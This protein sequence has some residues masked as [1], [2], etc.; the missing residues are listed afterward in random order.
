MLGSVGAGF[1]G[2]G[3]RALGSASVDASSAVVRGLATRAGSTLAGTI[4]RETV[5]TAAGYGLNRAGTA[6]LSRLRPTPPQGQGI[7]Y[8][9][10]DLTGQLKPY[11]GQAIPTSGR[12]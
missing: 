8:L 5:T 12:P 7:V 1:A 3:L 2:A 11:V 10:E 4:L 9:R 6:L